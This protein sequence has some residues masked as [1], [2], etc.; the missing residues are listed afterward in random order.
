M[1]QFDP[2]NVTVNGYKFHIFP[3]PAFKAANMSGELISVLG[4][5]LGSLLTLLGND[6]NEGSNLLDV[7]LEKSAPAIAGAF[8][9][10]NGDKIE[11]LLKRLLISGRNITVELEEGDAQYLTEDCLNE[12]FCGA[13]E[14]MY[15]LAF[16]VIKTNFGGFFKKFESLSGVVGEK[17]RMTTL[18]NDTEN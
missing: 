14:G 10:I 2:T 17:F 8:A 16:H 1:K 6:E 9:T 4:P 13:V 18:K 5:A 15:V 3:F 7:N 11:G 12:I